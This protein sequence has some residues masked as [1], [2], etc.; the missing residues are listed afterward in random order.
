MILLVACVGRLPRSACHALTWLGLLRC[1]SAARLSVCRVVL[2]IA[3]ARNARLVADT[4]A[5]I[6]VASSSDTSDT[7]DFLVTREDVARMLRGCYEETASVEFKLNSTPRR[8]QSQRIASL[9]SSDAISRSS[10][11]NEIVFATYSAPSSTSVKR[12]YTYSRVLYNFSSYWTCWLRGTVVERRSLAGELPLSCALPANHGWPLLWVNCPLQ[13]SQPGQLSLSS[14][15][16]RQISSKLELD[17][18]YRCRWR[19]L[20]KATEVTAGLVENNGSLPPGGLLSHLRADCLYTGIS[21][22]L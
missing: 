16:G 6:L 3:R 12:Q 22:E 21:S 18:C 7:P 8:I 17:V 19:H 11:S 20:V 4:L 10:S 2:Q 14:F 13:V 9:H 1:H 15:R 5:R